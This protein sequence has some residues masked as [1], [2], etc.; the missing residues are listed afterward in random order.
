MAKQYKF[1]Y[2]G[3]ALGQLNGSAIAVHGK[4]SERKRYALG[5]PFEPLE[6]A[7]NALRSFVDA[8]KRSRNDG[9]PTIGDVFAAYLGKLQSEGKNTLHPTSR[10]RRLSK[11]FGT[12]RVHSLSV[13]MCKDYAR[14]SE[15]DL[16]LWSIWGDLNIMRS[17][18]KWACEQGRLFDKPV[19]TVVWNIKVPDGRDRVLTPEEAGELVDA[20][21]MPHVRLFVL[22]CLLTGQ[23]H[24][25]VCDL[26]WDAVD[27]EAGTIDFRPKKKA[28]DVLDKS[29]TKGRGIV[30]MGPTLRAALSSARALAA[31]QFVIEYNGQTVKNCRQG[32]NVARDRAGLGLDVTPHILRHTA[33][34]W[35]RANA[36]V[37]TIAKM[38]GHADPRTTRGVYIHTTA[39]QS[40]GAT[41]A[42]ENVLKFKPRRAG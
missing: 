38:L 30:N 19:H 24:A 40:K 35:A 7:K 42:V 4:G 27:F 32:F 28:R 22:L 5:V 34:T 10:V 16:S 15:K 1:E 25:A 3:F 6:S 2:D 18:L 23:R 20:C 39:D 14:T 33:A 31:T 26:R 17:A 11:W 41:D 9:N 36:D 12:V 13:E 29:S 8:F 37:E 21:R